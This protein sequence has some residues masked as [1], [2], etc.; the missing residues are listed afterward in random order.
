MTTAAIVNAGHVGDPRMTSLCDGTRVQKNSP[1]ITALGAVEELNAQLGL[2]ASHVDPEL[3][4]LVLAVQ[5]DLMHLQAEL[6][7][8]GSEPLAAAASDSL[9]AVIDRLAAS[10]PRVLKGGVIPGGSPPAAACH[11]ARSKCRALEREIV[12]LQDADPSALPTALPY[13]DR[14]SDLL[15]FVAQALNQ[16]AGVV[17]TYFSSSDD[18]VAIPSRQGF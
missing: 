17:P 11:V 13:V 4:A 1:Y 12:A 3:R 5:N 18:A 6:S 15:L 16:R 2:L 9:G 7:V 8:P 14:L 10:L